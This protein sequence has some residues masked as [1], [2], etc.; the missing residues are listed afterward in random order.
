[1]KTEFEARFTNINVEGIIS[2]II[3]KNGVLIRKR[4]LM[5]RQLFDFKPGEVKMGEKKWIRVRDESDK[6]TLTIK[7]II[8]KSK[9]DGVKETEVEVGNFEN[10]VELMN[11]IG[12]IAGPYQEN[13]REIWSLNNA[14]LSIDTWPGIESFLEIEAENEEIVNQ[15]SLILNLD[16][17]TANFGNIDQLYE[18]KYNIDSEKFNQIKRLD[19]NNYNAVL[20]N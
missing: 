4:G 1:M 14:V 11:N 6:I 17:K 13:Y 7:H 18:D 20:N 9:I 5:R 8:D 19:F 15:T 16:I 10:S 3:E 2:L 12:L